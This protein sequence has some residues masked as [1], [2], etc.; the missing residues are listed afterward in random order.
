M[1]LKMPEFSRALVQRM[2][3]NFDNSHRLKAGDVVEIV[4][5]EPEIRDTKYEIRNTRRRKPCVPIIYED[6][7]IIVVDKPRGMVMYP[8]AGNHDGTLVQELSGHCPLSPLGGLTRP[9][10][11]H[12][13]DKDTSGAVILAKTDAAFR[14]LVKVFSGHKLTRK[15]IAFVW[16][17]PT[18]VAADIE[19]NIARNSRNR[20]KMSMVKIGG[21]P[22]KTSVEVINVW[23]RAG[24]SEL[25]CALYTGRTHQIRVHL[26]AHGFPVLTDPLYGR[27]KESKIKQGPLLDFLRNHDGQCLHAETLELSHPA[28]GAPMKF[29]APLPRDLKELKIELENY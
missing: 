24:V 27:G 10:V 17:V 12:R 19:G 8:A 4:T 21:R 16:N 22:A 29:R 11:V 18:W 15:Y 9:G 28:T 2:E 14:A 23:T 25:R 13:I 20:Q 1:A 6:D 7:D 5:P 26:S 3:K